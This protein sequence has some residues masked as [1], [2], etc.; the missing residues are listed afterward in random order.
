MA[1]TSRGQQK[2]PQGNDKTQLTERIERRELA[3]YQ[4]A[5]TRQQQQQTGP[6]TC[7]G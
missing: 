6:G 5:R 2:P 7:T 3:N 4:Q 1:K